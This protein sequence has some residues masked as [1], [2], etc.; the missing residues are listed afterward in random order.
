MQRSILFQFFSILFGS[1]RFFFNPFPFFYPPPAMTNQFFSILL[2][3][4]QFFSI[5][6]LTA[7]TNQFFSILLRSNDKSI[8][9]HAFIH[10]LYSPGSSHDED[11]PHDPTKSDTTYMHARA[12]PERSLHVLNSS[13]NLR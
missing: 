4:N 9:I 2:M 1:G 11:L 12:C 3:T 13:V 10:V 7:M 8:P 6:L 5:L